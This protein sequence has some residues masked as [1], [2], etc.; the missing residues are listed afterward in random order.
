MFWQLKEPIRT[1]PGVSVD[2]WS[3]ISCM[4]SVVV[5]INKPGEKLQYLKSN[6]LVSKENS[7][8]TN[9]KADLP[10][11]AREMNRWEILRYESK[12]YN[13]PNSINY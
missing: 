13:H 7:N 5:V 1:Q 4:S 2:N 12:I 6:T 8:R 11:F 3:A 9:V 10:G